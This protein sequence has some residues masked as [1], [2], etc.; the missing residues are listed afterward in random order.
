MNILDTQNTIVL[1]GAILTSAINIVGFVGPLLAMGIT[2]YHLWKFPLHI[3]VYVCFLIVNVG[4]NSGLKI[5]IR[6]ARPLGGKSILGESYNGAD[7]YGMPSAHAQTVFYSTVYLYFAKDSINW[8]FIG[9][10]I[11]I[12]TMYQRWSYRRHTIPQLI[13]G[14]SIGSMIAYIGASAAKYWITGQH[15]W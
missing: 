7:E 15:F 5:W 11:G 10:C 13:A 6:Q 9:V 14:M 8:L 4:I 1:S 2:L 12:I 3:F